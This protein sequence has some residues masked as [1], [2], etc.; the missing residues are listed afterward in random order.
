MSEVALYSSSL[1]RRTPLERAGKTRTGPI[2]YSVQDS[3]SRVQGLGVLVWGLGF[4][5]SGFRFQGSGFR[6][7][8]SGSRVQG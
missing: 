1:D 4:R 6:V 5:V 7:Q 3:G 2:R 8:G